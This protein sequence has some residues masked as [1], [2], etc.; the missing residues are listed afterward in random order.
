MSASIDSLAAELTAPQPPDPSDPSDPSDPAGPAVEPPALDPNLRVTLRRTI[1][2]EWIKLWSVRSNL[3]GLLGAALV[4]I[5]VGLVVSSIAGD[6]AADSG[7]GG[8]GVGYGSDTIASFLSGFDMAQLI[9]GVFGVLLVTSEYSTGMIRTTFAAV[10]RRTKVVWAKAAT[11]GGV[12]F[13]GA[14]VAALVAVVG[15]SALYGGTDVVPSLT[16]P[17]VVR[18]IVG[19]AVF[20]AGIGL[21]GTALGWLLRS[22]AA[23]IGVLVSVLF[24]IPTLVSLLPDVVADP[25][26]KVMPSN[27][28][29]AVTRVVPVDALLS[30]GVGFAVFLAW[31]VGLLVVAGAVLRRRDA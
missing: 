17:D 16:D 5:V 24:L 4:A 3:L 23:G 8:P 7:D 18:A 13:V 31:V 22:T 19:T 11:F 30:P 1:R 10:T 2:S 21:L 27:A 25:L 26:T 14:L 15:G 20:T 28:G 29:T 6:G 12:V 9:V